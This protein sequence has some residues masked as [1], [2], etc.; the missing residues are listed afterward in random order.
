MRALQVSRARV[1]SLLR[2]PLGPTGNRL[3][4][5]TETHTVR[6]AGGAGGQVFFLEG[7]SGAMSTEPNPPELDLRVGPAKTARGLHGVYLTGLATSSP[8]YQSLTPLLTR[9][10]PITADRTQPP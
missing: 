3:L 6:L 8:P 4:L 10:S 1:L 2:R 9:L 7:F 5:P